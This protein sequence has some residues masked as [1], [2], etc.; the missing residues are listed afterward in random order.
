MSL[1]DILKLSAEEKLNMV[2]QILDSLATDDVELSSNQRQ[3]LDHR[4]ELDN[5]GEMSW[6]SLN[7]VKS[8]LNKLIE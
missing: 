5:K 1:Q 6:L 4:M 7:E 3:E 2:D 8:R